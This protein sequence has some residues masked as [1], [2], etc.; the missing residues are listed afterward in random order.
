MNSANI[1]KQLKKDGWKL[2]RVRGS[3]HIFKK[4]GVDLPIVISHP[5]KDMTIGQ[6]KDVEKKSGLTFK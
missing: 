2:V 6:V 3:H 4:E 5:K 1:I